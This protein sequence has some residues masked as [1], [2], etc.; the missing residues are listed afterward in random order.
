VG[1]RDSIPMMRNL[2]VYDHALRELLLCDTLI[3]ARPDFW[4]LLDKL[5]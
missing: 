2:V 3:M 5:T 4:M 1:L